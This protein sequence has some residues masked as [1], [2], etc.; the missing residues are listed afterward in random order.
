MIKLLRIVTLHVRGYS[1][2]QTGLVFDLTDK[3]G[4]LLEDAAASTWLKIMHIATVFVVRY[5]PGKEASIGY[6]PEAWHIRYIGKEADKFTIL[7]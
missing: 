4:N 7:V 2:H 1:E 3:A 5:Q 6:M